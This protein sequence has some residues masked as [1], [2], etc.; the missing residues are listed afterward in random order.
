MY[1][2]KY[3]YI[4]FDKCNFSYN[5]FVTSVSLIELCSG[6]LSFNI[7]YTSYF[8]KSSTISIEIFLVVIDFLSSFLLSN[9]K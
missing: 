9:E 8:S 1:M 5:H 3:M 4:H 7:V 6:R 2:Y